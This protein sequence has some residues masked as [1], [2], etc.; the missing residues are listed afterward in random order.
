MKSYN[1]PRSICYKVVICVITLNAGLYPISLTSAPLFGISEKSYG[2]TL[3]TAD[4]GF[5]IGGFYELQVSRKFQANFQGS[6]FDV[7]GESELP[8]YDIYTGRTYKVG[9]KNLLLVPLFGGVKYHPFVD[10]IAN[11]FSPLIMAGL[12]PIIILDTPEVGNF[13]ERWN[14]VSTSISFGGFLYGGVE[15]YLSSNST[16][17][18]TMGYNVFPMGGTVDGE[19]NYNGL[20]FK[21]MFGKRLK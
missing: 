12:G 2:F 6:F 14:D 8:V 21:F 15:I 7:A 20:I 10:Q 13:F 5:S 19:T 4:R 3:G 18:V 9:T 11:N 1:V 16:A 17:T